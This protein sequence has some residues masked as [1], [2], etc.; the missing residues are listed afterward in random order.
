MGVGKEKGSGR[1]RRRKV[2]MKKTGLLKVGWI[3]LAWVGGEEEA[4][5][6]DI[7]KEKLNGAYF[8]FFYFNKSISLRQE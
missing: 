6:G 2:S 5:R 3:C 1:H 7:G 4:C 8:F